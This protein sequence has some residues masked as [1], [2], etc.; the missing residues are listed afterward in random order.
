MIAEV[1]RINI[2]RQTIQNSIAISEPKLHS[3]LRWPKVD[4]NK[5]LE[6]LKVENFITEVK[7]EDQPHTWFTV[8]NY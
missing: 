1:A 7:V 4:L 6:V 8:S 2:L 3:I 5:T